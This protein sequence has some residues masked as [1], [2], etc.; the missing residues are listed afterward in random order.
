M[1][2]KCIMKFYVTRHGEAVWN[3]YN[4]ICGRTD[5]EL[6]ERGRAQA[7][8]LAERVKDYH[9]DL[10][11]SSP[12]QRAFETARTVANRYHIPLQIDER[13]I[14]QH[15]GIYEGK[16]RKDEG[17]LANKRQFAYRYPEGGESMMQMAYR[18]YGFIEDVKKNYPDKNV[19]AVCHGGVCRI[20][21]TYF[22]D[23]TNDEFFHYYKE[24][25]QIEEYNL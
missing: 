11:I 3:V 18:V 21:R 23:M 10:I 17:F 6:T 22:T 5:V 14:E 19:L 25:C 15:Y 24:N 13:L 16:D 12:L 7:E 4:K 20:I 9:I 1:C 2:R 8:E